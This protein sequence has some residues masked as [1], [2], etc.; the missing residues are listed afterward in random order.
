MF[1]CIFVYNQK[2]LLNFESENLKEFQTTFFYKLYI[3]LYVAKIIENTIYFKSTFSYLRF[4]KLLAIFEQKAK[5]YNVNLTIDESVVSY[6]KEK[7]LHIEERYKLGNELKHHDAKVFDRFEKYK[8]IVNSTMIRPLRERQMWDSFFMYA[9]Q[10]SGNFSV[11][12]SGKTAAAL[13]VFAYLYKNQKVKR[14]VVVS[15]KN[16]FGSWIDEFR[17]SF[18]ENIPLDY[19]ILHNKNY[20]NTQE[21]KNAILYDSGNANLLLFNYES[22]KTY[23]NEITQII[24][25]ETLLVFDEVHKVKKVNGE[26]AVNALKIAENSCFTIAMTG[27]PIPNTYLD[28]YNFLHILFPNEYDDF[29][30]FEANSLKNPSQ[31]MIETINKRIQPFFCR[32]NKNQLNVPV[33]N[34]E[35]IYFFDALKEENEMLSILLK[36]YRKNKLALF[37]RILQLETNPKLLLESLDLSDFAHILDIAVDDEKKI[38]F[39][40]YSVEVQKLIESI[41]VTTKFKKCIQLVRQLISENKPVIIWCIFKDSIKHIAKVLKEN[42]INAKCIYGEVE[43]EERQNLIEAF[44]NKEFEVLITNPHTLAESVSLHSVCHDAIYFEYS[45]NL[46][47]LLQSKDRIHRLGLPENQYTQYYFLQQNY[48]TFEGDFSLDKKVYERLLEKEQIMLNAIDNDILETM[49]TSEEELDMIFKEFDRGS[50]N[51]Q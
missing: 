21:K 7:E 1:D 22:L 49:P 26:Y 36:K 20:K 44:K 51:E 50:L 31:N 48:Q 28:I 43:L 3:K 19:F 8:G 25:D 33:P 17:F 47:H 9:M 23:C 15:P 46:V 4:K 13:G 16:A 45:Y 18:G 30:G 12:G 40:D 32:T 37:I 24:D 29:F 6:L 41:S 35:F 10:K 39:V 34:P 5:Q 42:E 27:T 38:D 2:F 11:P 14:I